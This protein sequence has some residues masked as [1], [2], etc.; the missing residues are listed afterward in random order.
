MP[1]IN[2]KLDSKLSKKSKSTLYKLT[3]LLEEYVI[4]DVDNESVMIYTKINDVKYLIGYL[5]HKDEFNFY[6]HRYELG[7][8]PNR[9]YN[10]D[11]II[12]EIKAL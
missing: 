9:L 7:Q 6:I 8:I 11:D 4:F 1:S 10:L 12:S 2:E 3:S 5:H